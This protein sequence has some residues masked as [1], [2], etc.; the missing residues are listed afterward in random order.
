MLRDRRLAHCKRLRKLLHRSL[1]LHKPRQ[2]R[3]PR[4]VGERRKRR[5]QLLCHCAAELH[6]IT[7]KFYNLVVIY[8]IR[9]WNVKRFDKILSTPSE[10]L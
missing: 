6:S 7:H 2:D 8:K 3:S 10:L 9:P 1:T 5:I 4:R